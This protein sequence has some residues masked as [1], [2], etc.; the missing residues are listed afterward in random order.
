MSIGD[1]IKNKVMGGGAFI[2]VEMLTMT[3]FHHSV[4]DFVLDAA[5]G[6]FIG[7]AVYVG[8]TKSSLTWEQ[9]IASKNSQVPQSNSSE[10]TTDQM[11]NDVIQVRKQIWKLDDLSKSIRNPN[12]SR[13]L[14]DIIEVCRDISSSIESTPKSTT[15][16]VLW[17]KEYF[18]RFVVQ[19]EKYRDLAVKGETSSEVQKV[20]IEF[21]TMLPAVLNN[22]REV[23]DGYLESDITDFS[24][25]TA[26]YNRIVK[27]TSGKAA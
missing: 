23:L 10:Q 18:P 4:L 27:N 21:E 9:Y 7:G 19:T 20:L 8:N 13:Q 11:V 3:L 14:K 24:V 1:N 2:A 5:I 22:F 12:I 16:S 17:I 25:S 15:S 26:V 6:T